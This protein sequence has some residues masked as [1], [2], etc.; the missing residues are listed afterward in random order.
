MTEQSGEDKYIKCSKCKCKYINDDKHIDNDFGFNR[1]GERYKSCTKCRNNRAKRFAC[2]KQEAD[3]SNGKLKHCHRC[4][5]NKSLDEFV[6]PNGRSYGAC[7][8]CLIKR[9]NALDN[10]DLR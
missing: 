5:T 6:C 2:L 9:F 7:Y 4:Y 8:V 10:L 3:D 1:L